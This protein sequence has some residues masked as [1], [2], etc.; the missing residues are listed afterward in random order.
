MKTQTNRITVR[1]NLLILVAS[2]SAFVQKTFKL[3]ESEKASSTMM[4][5]IY[6][7]NTNRTR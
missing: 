4:Q 7:R 5:P 6:I 3:I 1:R 2:I